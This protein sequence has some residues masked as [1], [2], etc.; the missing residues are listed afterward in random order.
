M[1]FYYR[2]MSFDESVINNKSQLSAMSESPKKSHSKQEKPKAG[3]PSRGKIVPPRIDFVDAIRYL[4]K[5]NDQF[6]DET[7]TLVE[8]AE[9][10]GMRP[11]AAGVFMSGVRKFGLIESTPH[12][13]WRITDLGKGAVRN[14]KNATIQALQK[15]SLMNA[16]YTEFESTSSSRGTIE[17]FV[18]RNYP[19]LTYVSNIVNRFENAMTYINSLEKAGEIPPPP[20]EPKIEWLK[21]IQL[22]YAL[23]SPSPKE[24]SELASKVAD[25]IENSKDVHIKALSNRMRQN[26][27]NKD[28]LI[29]LVDSIMDMLSAQYPNLILTTEVKKHAPKKAEEE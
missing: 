24:I 11:R 15:N 8:I 4:K 13:T 17:K 14:E 5:I 16:L 2:P 28:A 27:G 7:V 25:E 21:I 18:E 23:S 29:L 22:K 10:I 3:R 19:K 20:Q 6:G 12:K 1:D 9:S 26:L